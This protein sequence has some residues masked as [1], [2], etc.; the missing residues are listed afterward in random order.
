MSKN[1]DTVLLE[2]EIT[3]VTTWEASAVKHH[4]IF[5]GKLFSEC[6][7]PFFRS[8]F[9][10]QVHISEDAQCIDVTENVIVLPTHEAQLSAIKSVTL[11]ILK[12]AL[13]IPMLSIFLMKCNIVNMIN[14]LVGRN[15]LF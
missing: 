2:L 10:K 13:L 15:I 11:I 1:F 7:L 12:L 3:I 9:V 4:V 8:I 14:S 5:Y 6:F